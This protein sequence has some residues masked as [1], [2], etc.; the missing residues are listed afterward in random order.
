MFSATAF[1][2]VDPTVGWAKAAA[3]LKVGGLLALLTHVNRR[4]DESRVIQDEFVALLR[5]H[6]P[7]VAAQ[8][9]QPPDFDDLIA[10]AAIR[11]DNV[12]ETW[13]WLMQGGLLRPHM[14]VP[15]ARRLFEDIE[16]ASES[17]TVEVTADELLNHFRTTAL[18]HQ[19]DPARRGA[20]E[21]DDRRRIE[22]LGGTI[23]SALAVLLLTAR[24][25]AASPGTSPLR[26]EP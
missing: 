26:P 24:R 23:R 21:D 10:G 20:F 16:V 19:I 5:K 13:D 11:R 22:S 4:D 2:W 1:H 15:E 7:E 9:R 18:Y 17:Y 12:S 3:C 6:A 14:A 25:S 8:W